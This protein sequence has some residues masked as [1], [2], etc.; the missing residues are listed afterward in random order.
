MSDFSRKIRGTVGCFE[1]F[2]FFFSFITL[3]SL[4]IRNFVFKLLKLI[5]IHFRQYSY[6]PLLNKLLNFRRFNSKSL[7]QLQLLYK[8]TC[9]NLFHIALYS[10]FYFNI[11]DILNLMSLNIHII[12]R[13]Y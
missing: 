8:K 7:I 4:K 12:F 3:H 2:I 9:N 1:S 11:H 6:S 5:W 10:L 13:L